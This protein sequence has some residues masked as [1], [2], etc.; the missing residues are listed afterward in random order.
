MYAVN[1]TS[2]AWFDSKNDELL[3]PALPTELQ[4]KF[5]FFVEEM[6]YLH[7]RNDRD[8]EIN[9]KEWFWFQIPVN[10]KHG[11]S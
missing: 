4:I 3:A 11:R 8:P 10:K 7:N 5:D 1:L 2:D 6:L 9:R